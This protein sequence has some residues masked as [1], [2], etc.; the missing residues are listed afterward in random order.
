M[1]VVN[2]PPS[3]SDYILAYGAKTNL[4]NALPAAPEGAVNVAWQKD[5]Y[6]NISGYVTP[7]ELI[8]GGTY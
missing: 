8:D 5:E 7:N 6:G 4:N 1:K 2:L 3:L